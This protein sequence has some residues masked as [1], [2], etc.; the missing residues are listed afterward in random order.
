MEGI[1]GQAFKAPVSAFAIDRARGGRGAEPHG[2]PHPSSPAGGA[3]RP[4][5]AG[6]AGPGPG[7]CFTAGT[8]ARKPIVTPHDF[9]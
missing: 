5:P 9:K 3:Q 8:A 2:E 6:L 4:P 7:G 1:L